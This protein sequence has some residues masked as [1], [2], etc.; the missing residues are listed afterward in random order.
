MSADVES[1]KGTS[2]HVLKC[3]EINEFGKY[4]VLEIFKRWKILK[5]EDKKYSDRRSNVKTNINKD[6][7][8]EFKSSVGNLNQNINKTTHK[9]SE[10]KLKQNKI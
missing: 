3:I 2:S 5:L 7:I 10:G 4:T 6:K 8:D 1:S 9:T